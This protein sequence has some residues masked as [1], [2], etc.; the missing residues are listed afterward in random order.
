MFEGRTPSLDEL[1]DTYGLRALLPDGCLDLQLTEGGDLA[2]TDDRRDLRVGDLT[3][4]ALFRLVQMW[5]HQ[6]GPLHLLF[7]AIEEGGHVEAR[8]GAELDA[9]PLFEQFPTTPNSEA[10]S[11]YHEINDHLAAI[12]MSRLIY[13]GTV[14]VSVVAML[15]RFWKDLR[16][17]NS[18][19]ISSGPRFG[20]QAFGPLIEA[21][22]NSFR[23]EDEWTRADVLEGR[24]KVSVAILTAA[25]SA[26][27]PVI[28]NAC[29]D[30]LA[31]LAPE[32]FEGLA[33]AVFS[34]AKSLCM[35]DA[36]ST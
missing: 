21:A 30:V 23:H 12:E 26:Q 1:I 32:G 11:R 4:N 17:P 36:C 14:M 27:R 10:I 8:L 35:H 18:S 13:A 22:A 2:L 33:T 19:W 7:S 25:L 20:D 3:Q 16:A 29:P 28:R 15:R 5:R 6:A 31:L 9:L 34:F 24:Q